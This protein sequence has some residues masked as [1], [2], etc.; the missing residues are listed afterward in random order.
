V[1]LRG[2]ASIR[3]IGDRTLGIIKQ[4]AHNFIAPFERNKKNG[5]Q[6]LSRWMKG[7][8]HDREIII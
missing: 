7:K 8:S 5:N 2:T 4:Y 1:P 3:E 6:P